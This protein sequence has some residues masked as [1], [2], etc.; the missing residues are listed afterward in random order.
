MKKFLALEEYQGTL[1]YFPYIFLDLFL[2]FFF[3]SLSMFYSYHY[4]LF[5]PLTILY[6][7]NADLARLSFKEFIQ[8]F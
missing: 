2:S 3:N 1:C 7:K 6:F 8:K 5:L 4:L